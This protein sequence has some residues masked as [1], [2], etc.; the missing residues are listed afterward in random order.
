MIRNTFLRLLAGSCLGL[1]ILPVIAQ[2]EESIELQFLSFPKSIDPKPVELLLGD[3]RTQ[4][5]KIPTNEFSETYIVKR[6]E[7]WAVGITGTDKEG[8]QAFTVFGQAKALASAKQLILL[9]R[10]GKENEDGMVVLP[11]DNQLS[12]FGGGSF[13]FLNAAS[14]DVGGEIGKGT[15]AV[16]P[17]KFTI[18]KPKPNTDE[19]KSLVDVTL[20]YRKKEEAK[21]F[22]SSTW[23]TNDKARTMVFFY[24]DPSTGHLC[25]HSI[26]DFL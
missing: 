12:S 18:I 25:L 16:K 5:V 14:L 3:G 6:R 7:I 10:K 4:V 22:F 23:P 9:V 11:I 1:T 8:K 20:F 13:L 21:P 26:R 19:A 2:Q 17:G 15:F 24:E